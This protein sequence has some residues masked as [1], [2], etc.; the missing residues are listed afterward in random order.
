[1]NYIWLFLAYF[2]LF[3]L[4]CLMQ[5]NKYWKFDDLGLKC[6]RYRYFWLKRFNAFFFSCYRGMQNGILRHFGLLLNTVVKRSRKQIVI[7]LKVLYRTSKSNI[8]TT[9]TK[10]KNKN[11]QN[12]ITHTHTH[13]NNNRIL[14]QNLRILDRYAIAYLKFGIRSIVTSYK[15]NSSHK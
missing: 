12:K 8:L 4:F 9:K 11:K 10:T 13:N 14:F 3:D 7:L 1:M 6:M 5:R 2:E 15:E